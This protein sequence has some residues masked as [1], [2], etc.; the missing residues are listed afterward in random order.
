LTCLKNFPNLEELIIDDNQ[1]DDNQTYFPK[2]SKLHTLMINK[3]HFQDIYQLADHLRYAYPTLTYLSLLGNEVC[4]YGILSADQTS[5]G[6]TTFSQHRL[7]EEYRRYRHLLVYRIPTL[8]FLDS[9]EI[10]ENE[11]RIAMQLGDILY[12]IA[13]TKKSIAKSSKKNYKEELL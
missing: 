1:L 12:S 3:N 10:S 5:A 7:D 6:L 13:E 4:P 11:R 8:K 9:C 2:L